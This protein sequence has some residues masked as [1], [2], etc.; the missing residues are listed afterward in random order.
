MM[1]IQIQNSKI[2][3][4]T[5]IQYCYQCS[6]IPALSPIHHPS[7][8]RRRQYFKADLRQHVI[9]PSYFTPVFAVQL[10]TFFLL[11][12]LFFDSEMTLELCSGYV[13]EVCPLPF[14]PCGQSLRSQ[15]P[16]EDHSQSSTHL[17]FLGKL[18]GMPA[19]SPAYGVRWEAGAC[20]MVLFQKQAHLCVM[21]TCIIFF[22][23]IKEQTMN[24]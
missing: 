4:I 1:T 7:V 17:S 23:L 12:F 13:M 10:F 14:L 3:L 9:S 22:K 19:T 5:I 8:W 21:M 2:N 18:R 6:V 16:E 11:T 24:L 15:S 20:C